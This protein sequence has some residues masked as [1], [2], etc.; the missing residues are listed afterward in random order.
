VALLVATSFAA[1]LNVY[2]TVGTLGLLARFGVLPLPEPGDGA[3]DQQR[4][5]DP[6]SGPL[7]QLHPRQR[8]YGPTQSKALVCEWEQGTI[9][10]YYRGERIA[11]SEMKEPMQKAVAPRRPAIRATMTNRPARQHPWRQ[12]YQTM[13]PWPAKHTLP[14][15]LME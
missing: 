14:A 2:A 13:K 11:F 12:G 5:G 7:E 6:T 4:L 10:V 1:V 8:R 9:Q 15:P 3:H